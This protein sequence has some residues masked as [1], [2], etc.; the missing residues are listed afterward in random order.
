[1]IDRLEGAE[2]DEGNFL[3]GLDKFLLPGWTEC[4]PEEE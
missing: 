1:M 2:D 3:V 4:A